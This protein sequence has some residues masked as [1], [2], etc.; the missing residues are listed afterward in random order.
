V[1]E[2]MTQCRSMN[3]LAR[4]MGTPNDSMVQADDH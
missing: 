1:R 2:L 3:S 4:S